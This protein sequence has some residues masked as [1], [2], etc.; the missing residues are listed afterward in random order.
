MGADFQLKVDGLIQSHTIEIDIQHDIEYEDLET[1]STASLWS[2]LY[3]AGYL[4][5]KSTGY[6]TMMV[7]IP[8]KEV[9]S[10]WTGWF[11]TILGSR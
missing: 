9:L 4:T 5:G 8:N 3:Y 11:S 1:C 10:E 6:R 2:L 7:V